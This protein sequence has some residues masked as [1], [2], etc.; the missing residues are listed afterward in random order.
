MATITR[1]ILAIIRWLLCLQILLRA[2]HSAKFIHLRLC[3]KFG[4]RRRKALL[5]GIK[6]PQIPP[7]TRTPQQPDSLNGD[8]GSDLQNDNQPLRGPHRD[9]ENLRDLLHGAPLQLATWTMH[10]YIV[11]IGIPPDVYCYNPRDIT[12]LIDDK[13]PEHVQPTRENIVRPLVPLS[14]RWTKCH[15]F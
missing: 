14:E 7:L 12:I 10:Q 5:I 11:L 2:I 8:P 13:N 6:G 9:V 4:T 1:P 3:Y 15:W